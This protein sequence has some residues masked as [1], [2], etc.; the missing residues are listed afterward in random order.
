MKLMTD[1]ISEEFIDRDSFILLE[2]DFNQIE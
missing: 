2:L 1:F